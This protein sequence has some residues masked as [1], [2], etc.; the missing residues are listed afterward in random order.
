MRDKVRSDR[1]SGGTNVQKRVGKNIQRLRLLRG[2]SQEE[3]AE[4]AGRSGK[5]LGQIERGRVDAGVNV[6]SSIAEALSVTVGDLFLE[7]RRRAP[8]SQVFLIT[9]RELDQIEQPIRRVR[10]SR[11]PRKPARRKP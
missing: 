2:L 7:A 8:A 10:A 3:L 9:N 11:A 5:H 4:R 6:L 1:R